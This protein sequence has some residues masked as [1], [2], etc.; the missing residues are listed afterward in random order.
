MHYTPIF[1]YQKST[2]EW[3]KRIK[4]NFITPKLDTAEK[5]EL[6]YWVHCFKI[7]E[8]R[9]MR[10][11][12]PYLNPPITFNDL[13]SVSTQVKISSS[14]LSS[15]SRTY[16]YPYVKTDTM[17]QLIRYGFINMEFKRNLPF[18]FVQLWLPTQFL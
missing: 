4:T 6:S 3:S 10:I 16:I 7:C 5:W 8:V 14:Y 15:S 18:P 13:M 9:V 17:P 2:T 11:L 12:N 1:T